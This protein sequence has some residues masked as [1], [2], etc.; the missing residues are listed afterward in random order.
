[1]IEFRADFLADKQTVYED[2]VDLCLA[3]QAPDQGF[4]YAERAKSRALPE[5]S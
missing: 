1:M 3:R 5:T 2:M 4:T